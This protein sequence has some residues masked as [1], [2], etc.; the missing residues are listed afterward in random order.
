MAYKNGKDKL[1]GKT[2][3]TSNCSRVMISENFPLLQNICHY[4]VE[5]AI[6]LFWVILQYCKTY[7][8]SLG[9]I[10]EEVCDNA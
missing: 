6:Y 5:S 4:H 10:L 8:Y 2:S 9:L 7:L 3:F 1:K